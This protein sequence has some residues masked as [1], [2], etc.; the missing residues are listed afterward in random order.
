MRQR[1]SAAPNPDDRVDS[2]DRAA[3]AVDE[4]A[5]G[6]SPSECSPSP[7]ILLLQIPILDGL[8]I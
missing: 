2:V 6:H 5:V 1:V 4:A 8:F 3:D 7:A